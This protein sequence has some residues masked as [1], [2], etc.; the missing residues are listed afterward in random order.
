MAEVW[1]VRIVLI[2]VHHLH[3]LTMVLSKGHFLWQRL[4]CD[5]RP[6]TGYLNDVKSGSLTIDRRSANNFITLAG[7]DSI[8]GS[9]I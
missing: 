5:P 6:I 3:L 4:G 8:E 2:L 7:V 9:K 1:R